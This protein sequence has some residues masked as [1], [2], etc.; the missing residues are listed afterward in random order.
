MLATSHSFDLPEPRPINP[1]SSPAKGAAN[2]NNGMTMEALGS[3]RGCGRDSG[4][5][6]SKDDANQGVMSLTQTVTHRRVLPNLVPSQQLGITSCAKTPR[7]QQ[8]SPPIRSSTKRCRPL[9]AL[10]S[11]TSGRAPHW[12][13]W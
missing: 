4:I 7:R 9:V 12:V 3:M 6:I 2:P 1:P 8:S 5:G 10:L 13:D 11:G